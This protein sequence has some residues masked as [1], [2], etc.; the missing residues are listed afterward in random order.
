MS[1]VE[2]TRIDYGLEAAT[3]ALA[4]RRSEALPVVVLL[5]D[6]L[7][8]GSADPVR[9]ASETLRR[10]VPEVEVFTIGLG[11]EIDE[12]LL[13]DLATAADGYYESPSSEDLEAI[14]AAISER[15]LCE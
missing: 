15:I 8:N 7:Q 14:Y 2:G 4:E 3:A 9:D 1:T 5:S 6:G 12:A 11:T 13:R 10:S